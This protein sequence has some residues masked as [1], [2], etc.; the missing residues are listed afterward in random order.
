MYVCMYVCMM[1]MMTTTTTLL[2]LLLLQKAETD[3]NAG[4]RKNSDNGVAVDPVFIQLFPRPTQR[5]IPSKALSPVARRLG[6]GMNITPPACLSG[7][8]KSDFYRPHEHLFLPC[9]LQ[10][11]STSTQECLS[12][13]TL[14]LVRA[15]AYTRRLI[16]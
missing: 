12:Y 8:R 7:C 16:G 6:T 15:H 10:S 14:D 11:R 13:E 4:L 9:C 5:F 1:M 3:Q 2:L